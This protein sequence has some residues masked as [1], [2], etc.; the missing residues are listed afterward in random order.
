MG[1]QSVSIEN[2]RG[3]SRLEITDMKRVN[4]LVGRNNCGKTSVL[5]AIFLLSG[6]SNPRLAMNIHKYRSLALSD[7]EGFRFMFKDL[8]FSTPINIQG[9]INSKERMLAIEPQYVDHDLI[10]MANITSST[11]VVAERIDGIKFGFTNHEGKQFKGTISIKDDKVMTDGNYKE[12][13]H[14]GLLNSI[15]LGASLDRWMGELTVHK[16]LDKVIAV[17]Q[18][19]EPKVRDI[20]MGVG[21]MIYVDIG[22]ETLMP[23]NIMGDGM[24]RILNVM[25]AIASVKNGV[26]LIDEIE[27]GLHYA[28]LIVL[29]KA[30]I[31]ACEEYDV[32]L[33][34]TTHSYECIEAFSNAYQELRPQGDD[35]RL[36]R[37]DRSGDHHTAFPY[38]AEV[39]KAGIE[40]E[41]EVR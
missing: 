25:T 22:Q 36:F 39:L 19:I 11:S 5:E 30:I 38:T 3:I 10:P 16:K 34:A 37:I 28:S 14:C 26:I 13:L 4:L 24:L 31:A 8:S 1:Y 2:F 23:A 35:I 6:M 27:N 33:V 12:D 29:W 40:K 15:T 20:R 7:D 9:S 18:A 41:Y 17:L 32:Q 21:G